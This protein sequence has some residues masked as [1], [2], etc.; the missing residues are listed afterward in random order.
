MRERFSY[1][2]TLLACAL[3]LVVI[4]IFVPLSLAQDGSATLSTQPPVGD[5]QD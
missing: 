3:S 4:V 2:T 1:S 5:W